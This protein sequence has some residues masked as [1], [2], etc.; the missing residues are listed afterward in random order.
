[1]EQNT[2]PV[3]EPFHRLILIVGIAGSGSVRLAFAHSLTI[4]KQQ[5]KLICLGNGKANR[6]LFHSLISSKGNGKQGALTAR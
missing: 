4:E 5:R 2:L 6:A 1:M 3:S